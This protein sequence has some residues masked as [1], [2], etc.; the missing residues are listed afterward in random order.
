MA[1]HPDGDSQRPAAPDRAATPPPPRPGLSYAAPA[2]IV[3]VPPTP[4]SVRLARSAWLLSF[5]AG[6]AVLIGSFLT[7]TPHLER[8]RTV[9]EEMAPG[10]DANAVT[11]SAAIVFWGSLSGLLLVTLLQAAMLAV[12]SARHGWAR[13]LM[14]LLL[15][16]QIL[17]M[18]VASAFLVPEGD[19]GRNV[20]LLWGSQLLL[21]FVG[22]VALFMPPA[23]RWLKAKRNGP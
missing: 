13:W 1:Q 6:L 18:A 11:T 21:A 22:L 12:V 4:R 19:A 9:V 23:G 14:I 5:V 16:G 3:V 20:V 2:P 7:R 17:V 15:A 8:L 10:G